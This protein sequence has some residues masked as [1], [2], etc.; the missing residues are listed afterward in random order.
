MILLLIALVA[1]SVITQNAVFA[2]LAIGMS[3]LML[4]LSSGSSKQ[5]GY[6][7]PFSGGSIHV[8]PIWYHCEEHG[9]VP[10]SHVGRPTTCPECQKPM[11]KGKKK[12]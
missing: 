3:V 7:S 12:S 6:F 10:I 1:I 9:N 5:S 11:K 4:L 8:E 2:W